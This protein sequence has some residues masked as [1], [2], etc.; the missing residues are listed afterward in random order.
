MSFF[1][2]DP[3]QPEPQHQQQQEQ[4]ES[5]FSLRSPQQ[6][7]IAGPSTPPRGGR[8]LSPAPSVPGDYANHQY[9]HNDDNLNDD[10]D[11]QAERQKQLLESEGHV[12]QRL[13]RRWMDERNAPDLLPHDPHGEM[14][15]CLQMLLRQVSAL[16][17]EIV[18]CERFPVSK[19]Q[20]WTSTARRSERP[21]ERHSQLG[22]SGAHQTLAR[23]ARGRA[24]E[25][26]RLQPHA[27]SPVQGSLSFE[28]CLAL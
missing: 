14:D 21:S 19:A 18:V 12:V 17:T 24:H 5:F 10:D 8:A 25:V 1:D 9:G 2:D 22:R 7:P 15:A 3:S 6:P 16:F 20:P 27:L 13:T 28:R 23:A 4:E 11:E 26:A